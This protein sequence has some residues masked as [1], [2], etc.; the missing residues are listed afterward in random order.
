MKQ[1]TGKKAFSLIE[2][3]VVV[4]IIGILTAV[5]VPKYQGFKAKSIQAEGKS[6]LSSI[7]TL[8]QATFMDTD[9]YVPL[10]TLQVSMPSLNTT[11]KYGVAVVSGPAS[12]IATAT[13]KA[14]LASCSTNATDVQTMDQD[15]TWKNT[16]DGYV[17]C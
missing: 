14:K 3:M 8:Q 15:H 11:G 6:L 16:T 4:A 17:G 13:S 12:F 9:G 5:G 1:A 7:Y 10:A 2:L